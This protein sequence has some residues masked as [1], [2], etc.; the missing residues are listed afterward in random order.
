MQLYDTDA[1]TRVLTATPAA[2]LVSK[3][4]TMVIHHI[5]SA[6]IADATDAVNLLIS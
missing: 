5:Y 3:Y 6:G 2:M 1:R 4:T